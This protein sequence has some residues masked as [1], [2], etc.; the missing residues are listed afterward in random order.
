MSTS[1]QLER[2][3]EQTRAQIAD[4]LEELRVRMTP[5]EVVDQLVDYARA[6]S[7]GMF[8]R[9]LKAQAI[10]NPVP[11]A[12]IGAGLTWLMMGG[13]GPT[14]GQFGDAARSARRSMSQTAANA[15][16]AATR[17]GGAA[18]EWGDTAAEKTAA[19]SDQ[20]AGKARATADEWTERTRSVA[21]AAGDQVRDAKARLGEAASSTAASLRDVA[22]ST[23]SKLRDAASSAYES[24][25][26]SVDRAAALEQYLKTQYGY[27]LQMS[28]T[29]VRDPIADFLFDRK[30]GHCEY[31]ASSMAVMLRLL[32]IPSRVVNGFRSDE[33]ND[34]TGNYIVR[35]KDAHSWVEAYFPG[36][37]WQTFDPTPGGGAGVPQGWSR[38]AL[39][40][41]AAASFWREWIIS[42]DASH[43]Y[44]L[45]QTALSGTRGMWEG[46]R[47]WARDHYAAML[48]WARRNQAR[49][50]KSPGRWGATGLVVALL[51][52]ALGNAGRTL[53]MLRER[54]LQLHPER[55][56]EQAASMWYRRM[57]RFL[58][59]Q[60]VPKP[61]AQTPREFVRS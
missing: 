27:T 19:A 9:N 5:G 21:G 47:V 46:A 32:G 34:L 1:K 51:L 31:F 30:Q 40:V 28:R 50:E 14:A 17:W 58:A 2:E 57:T 20:L 49:V 55:S 3:A 61:T 10:H 11:V 59:R 23:S 7:G 18:T 24:S 13:R 35:A 4:T 12:L 41:D 54:G 45:E 16:G 44:V 39:Y 22:T 52:L 43:Q 56:P 26:E 48:E 8:F 29:P 37:G 25:A 33:F 38:V 53:R 6:G 36:Y 60:G 15:A 42:Y